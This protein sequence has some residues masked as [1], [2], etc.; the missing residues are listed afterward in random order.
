MHGIITVLL[1]AFNFVPHSC[2]SAAAEGSSS[3]GG[4]ITAKALTAY[5]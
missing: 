5:G 1:E 3:S 2:P 4:G